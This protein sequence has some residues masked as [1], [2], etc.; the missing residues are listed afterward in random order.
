MHLSSR[1]ELTTLIRGKG[2][3]TWDDLKS[4]VKNLPYGRNK[5]RSDL[6]LVIKENKGT[7]SSKHAML[8]QIADLNGIGGIELILCLYKMNP[9]NTPG[10]G[11]ALKESNLEYMPEAHCFL[12][13]HKV[14]IDLTNKE[15]DISRIENDIIEDISIRPMEVN[16]FKV[17]YHKDYLMSWI[18][19]ERIPMSF[20]Q[21]WNIR[22]RCITNL[23]SST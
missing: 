20:D 5:Y 6:S 12:I 18:V 23:S 21:I 10:I 1:D 9:T 7:C 22:E 16:E 19:K 2:I 8:K 4:Y 14:S 11:S 15:S 3:N 13:D 17:N